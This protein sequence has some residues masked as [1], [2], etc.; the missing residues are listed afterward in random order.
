MRLS[1]FRLYLAVLS[2]L[3]LIVG[4]AWALPLLTPLREPGLPSLS[5]SLADAPTSSQRVRVLGYER[6][7]FGDWAVTG[8][9]STRELV[10]AA[11]LQEPSP[12]CDLPLGATGFDP[13][14]GEQ[15]S[16]GEVEVDHIFP[17]SAAW[18]SGAHA[19]STA[20]R[21]A[22]AN[23]PANLVGVAR[24]VN[25]AKSDLM[26]AQWLPPERGARCWYVRRLASVAATY[27]LSLSDGDRRVM[28]WQ[29]PLDWT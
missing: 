5:A 13:Y 14:T 7:L 12:T 17:L 9:C 15:F 29:C 27:Q 2:T 11:Q 3:T 25:Q 21:Q 23:D 20:Q 16:V 26:P 19:W 28:R 18:D 1:V 24:E 4:L 22:F 6:A 10:V 8:D